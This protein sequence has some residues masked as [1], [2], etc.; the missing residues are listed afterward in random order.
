MSKN[1]KPK[2]TQNQASSG[3]KWST[4]VPIIASL[5]AAL[6]YIVVAF[7]QR[8]TAL[9][10]LA[11]TQTAEF[12]QTSVAMT[13]QVSLTSNAG[14]PTFSFTPTA[15]LFDTLTPTLALTPTVS[16]TAQTKRILFEEDFID[17]RNNWITGTGSAYIA[18]GKYTYSVDCP[19]TYSSHY[20]GTYLH[21]PF[22]LPKDFHLE[23]DT[24]VSEFSENANFA[25]GFQFRRNPG[26]SDHYY[27]NYFITDNYYVLNAA[28]SSDV[29]EIIPKTQFDFIDQGLKVANRFGIEVKDYTFT[30]L[31]NGVRLL[32]GEDGN[33]PNAGD[34]YIV[35]YLERGGSATIEFD[36]LV[37]QEVN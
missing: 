29:L 3:N 34:A 16:P 14:V 27:I 28:Y 30:P 7:I 20:C 24:T 15:I 26:N 6:G 9:T 13:A 31:V 11:F 4:F 22:T 5:I 32:E 21:I 17:N 19:T 35:I 25:I 12:F 2:E 18:A 1:R 33:L 37:I 10:P 23:I 36:N 8:S